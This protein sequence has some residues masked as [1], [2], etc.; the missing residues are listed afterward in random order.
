[1]QREVSSDVRITLLYFPVGNAQQRDLEI[2]MC[3]VTLFSYINLD[4]FGVL[5]FTSIAA[6][7]AIS[8]YLQY[9]FCWKKK[10][11]HCCKSWSVQAWKLLGSARQ[12]PNMYID[13]VYKVWASSSSSVQGVSKLVHMLCSNWALA[14]AHVYISKQFQSLGTPT[15]T[16][17]WNWHCWI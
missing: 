8:I 9:C 5:T 10:N 1:M 15:V 16:Y 12:H 4:V 7:L 13:L 11:D 3:F 14:W 6:F 17:Y 2:V